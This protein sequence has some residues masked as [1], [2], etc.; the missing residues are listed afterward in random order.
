M[1]CRYLLKRLGMTMKTQGPTQP[2]IPLARTWRVLGSISPLF[3]NGGFRNW[4]LLLGREMLLARPLGIGPTLKAGVLAGITGVGVDVPVKQPVRPTDW[5]DAWII[6]DP[7]D[8]S[9]RRYAVEELHHIELRRCLSA[10][11][12]RVQLRGHKEHV[13]GLAERSQ[14]ESARALLRACYPNIYAERNFEK[15]WYSFIYG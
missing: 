10:N 11:E 13:Y 9:W 4:E 3:S 12:I 6:E 8:A 1:G 7:G 15:R 2:D 5:D 14:T